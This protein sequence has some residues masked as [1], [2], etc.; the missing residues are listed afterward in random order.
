[1]VTYLSEVPLQEQHHVS[2]H[3]V[4]SSRAWQLPNPTLTCSMSPPQTCGKVG[5]LLAAVA[6]DNAS[7]LLPVQELA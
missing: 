3:Q 1:M 4:S 6:V 2:M 5:N 7:L